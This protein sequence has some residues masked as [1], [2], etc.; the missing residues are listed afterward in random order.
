MDEVMREIRRVASELVDARQVSVHPRR[1]ALDHAAG[2]RAPSPRSTRACRCCR[3]TR[4]PTCASRSWARRTTMRARCA[5][6][7]STRA[8]TQ[9]G[10]R[11]LS[12]EEAAAVPSLPTDDLLRL[13][14]AAGRRLD[15]SRRRFAQRDTSTSRSTATGSI[16]RSC[17]PSARP[18][19]AGC[20]GTRRWRCCG[21]SSSARTVVGCDLVELS[22]MPG[23][24]APELPV[25]EADLQDPVVPVRR[26]G[27]SG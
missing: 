23:N 19:R 13:Q 18:S 15:R 20:R 12:P 5:A 24:V 16:R 8:T 27:A 10:I 4:M 14:H 1:R 3:S 22:P 25:R 17:R 7:S 6:R 11:S 26:G 21:G 2:R 9:V